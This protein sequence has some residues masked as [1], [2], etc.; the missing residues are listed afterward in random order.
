[1]GLGLRDDLVDDGEHPLALRLAGLHASHDDLVTIE[2]LTL[3][4][5]PE[6]LAAVELAASRIA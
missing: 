1:M 6:L 2:V 4:V 3:D 5:D